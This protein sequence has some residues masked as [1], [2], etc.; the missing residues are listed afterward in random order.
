MSET[1]EAPRTRDASGHTRASRMRAVE[2]ARAKK[3]A[4]FGADLPGER[5]LSLG[6]A[7]EISSMGRIRT[8]TNW[9]PIVGSKDRDGYVVV[10]VCGEKRRRSNL[11]AEAFIGPRPD[12]LIVC[13]N[14][15]SRDNDAADNL[16]Y[17]T[18]ADNCADKRAH[19][20]H[21][22]GSRHP[23]AS[24]TEEIAASIKRARGHART[25]AEDHGTTVHV[26]NDIR[27]GRT[28]AHA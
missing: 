10:C 25:V 16:R 2:S 18:Q 19:G 22:K 12:G 17:A 24:I 21:Q 14:D 5:W 1:T 8:I 3:R 28:W 15:G 26:V 11:V 7:H 9:R 20:T 23:R 4:A 13:H 27:R 6:L